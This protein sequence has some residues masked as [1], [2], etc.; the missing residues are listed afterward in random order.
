MS[1]KATGRLFILLWGAGFV[2]GGLLFA[3][4]GYFEAKEALQS[5]PELL[6][7]EPPEI[8]A[9]RR[10]HGQA[11]TKFEDLENNSQNLQF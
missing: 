4:L 5:G 7:F 9:R 11:E 1:A 3:T 6:R 8:M 10:N 2:L